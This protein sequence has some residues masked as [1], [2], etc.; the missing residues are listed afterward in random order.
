MCIKNNS[1]NEE[2]SIILSPEEFEMLDIKEANRLLENLR[3]KFTKYEEQYKTLMKEYEEWYEKAKGINIELYKEKF[4]VLKV[5]EAG[6]DYEDI[7]ADLK[8][9]RNSISNLINK[10]NEIIRSYYSVVNPEILN[11]IEKLKR[12]E[13]QYGVLIKEYKRWH[14]KIKNMPEQLENISEVINKSITTFQ[15]KYED[16][17]KAIDDTR[18]KFSK[19]RSQGIYI[20]SR[21]LYN[22]KKN[23]DTMFGKEEYEMPVLQK[24]ED[25]I[26]KTDDEIYKISNSNYDKITILTNKKNELIENYFGF[27]NSEILNI[28]DGIISGIRFLENAHLDEKEKNITSI[29]E[30]EYIELLEYMEMFLQ[31][32][33]INRIQVKKSDIYNI[34]LHEVFDIEKTEKITL[35][36]KIFKI[37]KYGYQYNEEIC[38]TLVNHIVRP[39]SVVIYKY[40]H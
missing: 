20:I 16:E 36:G 8:N 10:K 4:D 15:Q 7:C 24:L 6:K 30:D 38:N 9:N 35:D 11:I 40:C 23:I 26:Q 34:N 21:M 22:A 37:I 2:K 39:V 12:Y 29:I 14:K 33:G 18:K 19:G 27:V 31:S 1:S 32:I 28:I 25:V 3:N 5:W 17:I 13:E